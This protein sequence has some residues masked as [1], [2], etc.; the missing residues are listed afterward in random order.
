[1]LVV[2][3]WA[4]TANADP[5]DRTEPIYS[6][7][8]AI[9][10]T[11]YIES[12]M[13]S[14]SDGKKD[15]IAA[16]L[17]RP[18]ETDGDLK[19]PVIVQPSPYY[20]LSA[21]AVNNADRQIPIDPK[22]NPAHFSD[23]LHEYFVPRGYAYLE[24][25]MQGTAESEGCPTTGGQE[26]TES[27]K[28]LVDWIAGRA[29]A[30]DADGNEVAADWAKPSVGMIGISYNGTLPNAIAATGM[31]EVKAVVP[32]SA[33]S[34]WY[35]YTR[36]E[37]VAYSGWGDDYARWL[38]DYVASDRAKDMCGPVFDEL[39]EGNDDVDDNYTEFW[40]ERNYRNTSDQVTA[41]TLIVH[42][43]T[44]FNVKTNHAQR[45]W[46]ELKAND[47]P[48]KLWLHPDA[49]VGWPWNDEGTQLVHDWFDYWL[50]EKD[51]GVM[52]T[53]DVTV[54]RTDGSF[55]HYD[56]YPD[57]AGKETTLYFGG[58][59]DSPSGTLTTEPNGEGSHSIGPGLA[60][61]EDYMLSKPLEDKAERQVYLSEPLT[62]GK[63]LSGLTELELTYSSSSEKM[64][65]NALLVAYDEDGSGYEVVSRGAM[66]G[67]NHSGLTES[68]PLTPGE[69]YTGTFGFEARDYQFAEGKRIGVVIVSNHQEYSRVDE[70]ADVLDVQLGVSEL[71]MN[72][73]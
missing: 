20:G 72:L 49:H 26:D 71:R 62:E 73:A 38:A 11:V 48:T 21:A 70:S 25:E 43:Q 15:K 4:W 10:E 37:G 51:N 14:D 7:D 36:A 46:D 16:Q 58:E 69:S 40:D 5:D 56:D 57:P 64:P 28:A 39:T 67:R 18:A 65:I 12:E 60:P 66:D 30:V 42:G 1:M 41:G 61:D 24:V 3:G 44:D 6:L 35:D 8:D 9:K 22:A 63:H 19:V 32:I 27:M 23:W 59:A 2:A 45:L 33:I 52:D 54:E 50:Y 34:S 53:P 68:P 13:D 47:A 17:M 29:K 31:E 55:E